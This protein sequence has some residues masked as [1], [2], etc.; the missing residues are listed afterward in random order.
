MIRLRLYTT[1][2]C[3]LCEQLEALLATLCDAPHRLERVEISDDDALVERYGV[4][5]PVLVDEAGQEL[6]RGMQPERLAAWLAER[7]WLNEMAWQ[8]L[9]RQLS[10]ETVSETARG[11]AKGAVLRGGRRYLG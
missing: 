8:A 3:H 4:R 9:Q 10:G 6:D 1:L 2:G 11:E 5:I 7:G